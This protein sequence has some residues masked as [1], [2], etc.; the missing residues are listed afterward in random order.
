MTGLAHPGIA[1]AT[2]AG[3][4]AA[5]A[6][7]KAPASAWYALAI[8][9]GTTLFAFVDR[10]IIN[11]IAPS[12][13]RD[14][15]ISDLQLGM[16]QGLGFAFFA[17]LAAYPIG[18]LSDRFGRRLVL[19]CCIMVWSISTAACAFQTSFTGI[20]AAAA[21]IAIGEAALTPVIF[22]MLPDLF[23]ERQ[24]NTANFI[25]FAVA[26]LGAALGLALGGVTLNLLEANHG[27]LP[28][29]F[30]SMDSWRVALILVAAPGPLFVLLLTTI[31][32]TSNSGRVAVE[33]EPALNHILPFLREHW[34]AIASIYG[35]IFAYS[36]PLG[37]VGAWLPVAMPRAFD[38]IDAA[39]VGV[40]L[41]LA[42]GVGSIAGLIMAPIGIKLLRG[43]ADLKPLRTARF[44]L[45]VASLPTLFILFA[46]QPWQ[47]YAAV[48]VQVA[49][50]LATGAL[51]P[52]V[53][54]QLSPPHLRSRL[55]SLLGIS[56]AIATGL[57]PM[58]VGA[59]S[60]L[61]DPD[62][63]LLTAMVLVGLPAWIVAAVLMSL[64]R[65]PFVTTIA[66]IRG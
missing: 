35:A 39:S 28:A 44:Y 12:L 1:A 24:R 4:H 2:E 58:I 51:M 17:S 48:G 55:L 33:G 15:G 43:D 29:F 23:P 57:A 49:L 53:L 8:L 11:L 50:L 7:A 34:R 46:W 40:Q 37:A 45:T 26:L 30:A 10:Q 14:L 66:A 59:M 9:I 18:W 61:L 41:G 31:R 3:D 22:S 65:R 21:G 32:M 62:R 27:S 25:F 63:G 13:Q 5:G 38:G 60:G 20:F 42:M 19:G 64:A 6:G 47:I 36:L 54:Q 16:L 56:G 52:G